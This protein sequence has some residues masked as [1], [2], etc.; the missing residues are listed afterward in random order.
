MVLMRAR[1]PNRLNMTASTAA[2][3]GRLE[4]L[5]CPKHP[6]GS[7]CNLPGLQPGAALIFSLLLALH[8][9]ECSVARVPQQDPSVFSHPYA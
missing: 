7:A 6:L 3:S 5:R 4:S 2:T 8:L 9:L 1:W